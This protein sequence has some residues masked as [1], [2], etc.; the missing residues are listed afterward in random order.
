MKSLATI[1]ILRAERTNTDR[2]L[3]PL[4]KAMIVAPAAFYALKARVSADDV[5]VPGL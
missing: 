1:K 5:V 4:R 3:A 2:R